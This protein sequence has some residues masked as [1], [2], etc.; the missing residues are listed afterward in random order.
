MAAEATLCCSGCIGQ[1]QAC[2]GTG[3]MCQI[4]AFLKGWALP[5]P[6]AG[7]TPDKTPEA[8]RGDTALLLLGLQTYSRFSLRLL[9]A[10]NSPVNPAWGR[11]SNLILPTVLKT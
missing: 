3:W 4:I 10:L 8:S 2:P 6:S 11:T 5:L 9:G 7:P 1:S